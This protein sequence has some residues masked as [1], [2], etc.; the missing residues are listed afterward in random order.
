MKDLTPWLE[1]FDLLQTY[2]QQGYL[3]VFPSTNEAYITEPALLV[4]GI[5]E[6]TDNAWQ[7]AQKTFNITKYIHVYAQYLNAANEG[8]KQYVND[9]E[10]ATDTPA[11]STNVE[12]AYNNRKKYPKN[13]SQFSIFNTQLDK[14]FALHVV[15]SE[16]PHDLR[17]TILLT[18]KRR[19]FWPFTRIN[20]YDVV[21]YE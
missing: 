10:Q 6:P 12:Q 3:E 15:K 9:L 2:V 11:N 16:H 19:W 5:A 1:Y 20:N 13:N 4:L 14:P 17:Y 7:I 18:R 21:Y 8:Y